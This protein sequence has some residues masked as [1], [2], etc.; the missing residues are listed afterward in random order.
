MH[1]SLLKQLPLFIWLLLCPTLQCLISTLTQAGR[2][3][4][5]FRFTCSVVLRGGRGAA[6]KCHWPVWGGPAV[7]QLL[8]V[9]PHS[10]V[11]ALPIYTAQAPGCS[12][13]SG[14]CVACG[15][16][17]WVL[18]KSVDS[19]GPAFCVLPARAAQAARSLTGALSP[20]ALR[21]LPGCAAPSPLR[22]PSLSFW[23][24]AGWVR[25][26]SFLGELVSSRDPPGGC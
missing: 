1:L 11:C 20:G 2:G 13:W 7:F 15:S 10:R 3:G 24:G 26:V 18:H 14:P 6:D 17:F 22:G 25:L 19:V 23:L 4:L 5:S 21:L 16:S 12:I 8:W 9:C